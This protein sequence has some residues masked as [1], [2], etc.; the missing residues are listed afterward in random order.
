MRSTGASNVVGIF[1]V[2]LKVKEKNIGG[3]GQGRFV[4]SDQSYQRASHLV[5]LVR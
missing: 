5:N 4:L 1:V 3:T 2:K